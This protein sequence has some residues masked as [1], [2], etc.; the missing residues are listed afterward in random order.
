MLHHRPSIYTVLFS[1]VAVFMASAS[2]LG[3]IARREANM[4]TGSRGILLPTRLRLRG[5]MPSKEV[6][7]VRSIS[8]NLLLDSLFNLP[9]LIYFLER[10]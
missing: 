4:D 9:V 10:R 1:T 2:P 5:G 3:L 8:R 7:D 6:D